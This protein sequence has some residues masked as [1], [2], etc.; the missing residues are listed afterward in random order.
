MSDHSVIEAIICPHYNH[1]DHCNSTLSNSFVDV[2]VSQICEP[3][4]TRSNFLINQIGPN[5]Q[6]FKKYE[7]KV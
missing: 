2:D 4:H 6:Y 3:Y 1:Y 7:I 5:H